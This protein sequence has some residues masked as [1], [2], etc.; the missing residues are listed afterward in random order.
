MK[1]I[2][3]EFDEHHS[4]SNKGRVKIHR[5]YHNYVKGYMLKTDKPTKKGYIRVRLNNKPYMVHRLVA[6]LFVPNDNALIKTEINH[7]NFNR[8][9]NRAENLEWVSHA[10]NVR[11]SVL[12]G[13]LKN[14]RTKQPKRVL[15]IT[16]GEVFNSTKEAAQKYNVSYGAIKHSLLGHNRCCKCDWMYLEEQ[17]DNK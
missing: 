11:Y 9:D 5:N 15:N 6:Y 12:A 2:W 13:R 1:E 16:T 17:K 8:A 3:K 10:E 4:V 7:I 14:R